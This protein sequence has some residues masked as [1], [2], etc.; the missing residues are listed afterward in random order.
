M[1]GCA[2]GQGYR[3]RFQWPLLGFLAMVACGS[4]GSPANPS[5]SVSCAGT[6]NGSMSAKIDGVSWCAISIDVHKTPGLVGSS[7]AAFFGVAGTSSSFANQALWI[8]APAAVGTYLAGASGSSVVELH[9]GLFGP[10]WHSMSGTGTLK[11][12][13]S[14]GVSGTFSVALNPDTGTGAIGSRAVATGA[15]SVTF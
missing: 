4:N 3:R 8:A 7:P 10:Y 15:F 1:S 14:T 11:T 12:F 2:S 6:T 9:D 13:T 5:P